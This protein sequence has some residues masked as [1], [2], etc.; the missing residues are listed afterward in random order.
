MLSSTAL[1]TDI[2]FEK[3]VLESGKTQRDIDLL[4]RQ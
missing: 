1:W 4:K 3:G 2:E